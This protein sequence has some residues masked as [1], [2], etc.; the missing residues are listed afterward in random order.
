MTKSSRCSG[1]NLK[2]SISDT[3]GFK[4]YSPFEK[5][6]LAPAMGPI[7]GAPDNVSAADEAIIAKISGS[8]TKS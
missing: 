8:F 6:T 4:V 5:P 2:L 7:N 1:F 3:S